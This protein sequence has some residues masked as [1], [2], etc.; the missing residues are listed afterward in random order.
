[1]VGRY[2]AYDELERDYCQSAGAPRSP[3]SGDKR[4]VRLGDHHDEVKGQENTH[5]SGFPPMC[6]TEEG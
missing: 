3:P 4:G 6:A 2:A 5:E 1:V